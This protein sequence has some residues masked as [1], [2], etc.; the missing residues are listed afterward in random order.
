MPVPRPEIIGHRGAPRE[1]IEN[2]LPGFSRALVLGADAVELDVHATRDGTVVVHHDPVPRALRADGAAETRSIA[3]LAAS[4]VAALRFA[5]G[6]GIPTLDEALGLL[7]RDATAYVEIKGSG[8][9]GAVLAV[10][11]RHATPAAVH[12]FDHRTVR[13]V[14]A[15]RP[16]LRSGVL[17]SSYLLDPA[18]VMRGAGALDLWQEW[19]WIDAALVEAVRGAGGRVVAWTANDPAAIEAL[20]AIGVGAICTDLPAVAGRALGRAL[21]P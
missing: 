2:T 9:A 18:A 5:D 1:C 14:S 12:S 6:T 20:A 7:G 17:L 8:I 13:Q 10:L 4:E 21:A 19:S 3:S 11:A 16:A 15:A